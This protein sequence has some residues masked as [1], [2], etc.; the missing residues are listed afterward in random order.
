M[1][2]SSSSSQPSF[3]A[4]NGH[5]LALLAFLLVAL[6]NV[7]VKAIGQ[8]LPLAEIMAARFAIGLLVLTPAVARQGGWRF[9]WQRSPKLLLISRDL[10]GLLAVSMGFYGYV[11]LPLAPAAALWKTGP[12]LVTVLAAPVLGEL[13]SRR[14][15]LATLLGLGGML[16]MVQ[17]FHSGAVGIPAWPALVMFLGA[18]VAAISNLQVRSL[19]RSE[20]SITIVTWFFAVA[21][22]PCLLLLPFV[23]VWPSGHQ[24]LLLLWVGG[25]GALTQITLT[26]AYKQLPAATV[27]TYEY[28]ALVWAAFFGLVFW[29][30]W[31]SL[32][33]WL[34]IAMIV[35]SGWISARLGAP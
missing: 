28:S 30:E 26:A 4:C 9:T 35:G 32:L 12:L 13:V 16:L 18:I 3:Q 11:H 17:P 20:S 33:V 21:L 34:G 5:L 10:L 19:S 14:Q 31:P 25:T 22:L 6:G 2:D 24:L 29:G 27:A 1:S 7:G 8:N 15:W 23:G